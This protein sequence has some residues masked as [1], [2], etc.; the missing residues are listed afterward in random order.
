MTTFLLNKT[1][2]Y[3]DRTEETAILFQYINHDHQDIELI[4][5]K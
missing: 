3:I 4:D 1:Q 5:G 2:F